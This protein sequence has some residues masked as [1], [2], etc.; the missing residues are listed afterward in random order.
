MTSTGIVFILASIFGAIKYRYLVLILLISSLFQAAAIVNI[1]TRGIPV[2]SFIEIIFI[3]VSILKVLYTDK[4]IV[5]LDKKQRTVYIILI[6]LFVWGVLS[7]LVFPTTFF[8]G[9]PVFVPRLGIDAQYGDGNQGILN[10]TTSNIAQVIYLFLNILTFIFLSKYIK[11]SKDD[12]VKKLLIPVLLIAIF[13]AFYSILSTISSKI[14]FIEN[15]LYN[16]ISYS[17]GNNQR[18]IL[19]KRINGSFLEPSQA[20]AFFASFGAALFFYKNNIKIL[21]LF[22]ITF[23]ILLLTTATTGYI[24]FILSI[25]LIF[26]LKFMNMLFTKKYYISYFPLKIILLLIIFV[27]IVLI[28]ERDMVLTI[29]NFVLL[30]KDHSDSFLHRT[31]ADLFG[32]EIFIK[33]YGLGCGLGSSRSSS[34]ISTL[35]STIGLPGFLMIVAVVGILLKNAIKYIFTDKEIL[36]TFILFTTILISMILSNP[37]ISNSF[38]W[39]YGA[40]LF[41]LI[42]R[43]YKKGRNYANN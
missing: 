33:T 2:F 5:V 24:S 36:F 28:Y 23:I 10:F 35:L 40:L 43:K 3:V 31:F 20:G 21:I 26:F 14:P 9:M 37:D 6:S 19:F 27:G 11:N 1:G 39:I 25:S 7:A 13:F 15:F 42:L 8:S 16:N 22:S 30:H 41:G 4:G 17:I 32:L 12:I 34:I 29:L 38:F 18:S